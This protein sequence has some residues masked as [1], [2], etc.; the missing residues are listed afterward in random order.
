MIRNA[1]VISDGNCVDFAGLNLARLMDTQSDAP[2]G[3][4]MIPADDIASPPRKVR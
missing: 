3:L 4:L 1:W 2:T